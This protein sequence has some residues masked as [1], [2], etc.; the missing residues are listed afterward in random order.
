M[1]ASKEP[2]GGAETSQ[3]ETHGNRARTPNTSVAA[4]CKLACSLLAAACSHGRL[5]PACCLPISLQ[6]DFKW[7]PTTM[8]GWLKGYPNRGHP[9]ASLAAI[10]LAQQSY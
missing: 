10:V 4:S 8:I 1:E 5:T 7:F 2:V 9:R 6:V 3:N